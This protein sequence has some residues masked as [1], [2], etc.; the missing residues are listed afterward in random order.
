MYYIYCYT[1]KIN[2]HT[3]V[4]Q[5][6]DPV[7]R[8]REHES[9]AFNPKST[10]YNLLFHKKLRQYGINNFSFEILEE[11]PDGASQEEVDAREIYWIEAKNSYVRNE[12]GYNLTIGGS[13][14]STLVDRILDD[15]QVLE[16]IAEIKQGIP[17][18]QLSEKYG[19]CISYISMINHGTSFHQPNETYPLCKYY[20]TDEDYTE[21]IEL[22][23]NS[24]L[25]L[26]AIAEKLNM[27]YSTVKKINAGTLRK[28]LYHTYPIR[29]V[30]TGKQ[31]AEKIQS[32]LLNGASNL[33]IIQETGV[34]HSTITRINSGESYYNP[35]LKYPLR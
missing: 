19:L 13:G 14:N 31:R 11:L 7:R 30:S 24:D 27:G 9:N 8:N 3:Y 12:C 20:K 5:T 18:A 21:L 2:G 6:N 32:M 4:G 33:E 26:K 10:G 1:N 25:T 29:S 22:L 15:Q 35:L 16:L 28:G 34:S 17:F 23:T